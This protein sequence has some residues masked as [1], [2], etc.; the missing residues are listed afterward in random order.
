MK[1]FVLREKST[2]LYRPKEVSH[3]LTPDILKAKIYWKESSAK[4]QVT[5]E[6]YYGSWGV[7]YEVIAVEYSIVEI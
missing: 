4:S 6:K 2:G 1:A 7:D 5:N 3:G